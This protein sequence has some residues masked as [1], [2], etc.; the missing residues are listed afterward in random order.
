MDP[1]GMWILLS[2]ANERQ[3]TLTITKWIRKCRPSPSFSAF[4]PPRCKLLEIRIWVSRQHL[5]MCVD[6]D[7]LSLTKPTRG[8][9]RWRWVNFEGGSGY[10][11]LQMDRSSIPIPHAWRIKSINNIL[12]NT[13]NAGSHHPHVLCPKSRFFLKLPKESCHICYTT[14]GQPRNWIRLDTWGQA[15]GN[16]SFKKPSFSCMCCVAFPV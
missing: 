4:R 3:K 11:Q 7:S 13:L 2:S 15:K 1:L 8:W 14:L 6:I 10:H 5:P 12:L 9:F 16:T